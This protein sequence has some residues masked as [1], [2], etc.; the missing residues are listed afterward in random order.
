MIYV[1]EEYSKDL[2]LSLDPNWTKYPIDTTRKPKI[3]DLP[4]LDI[5]RIL[6]RLTFKVPTDINSIM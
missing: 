6:T 1:F 3:D 2:E 4:K 5:S